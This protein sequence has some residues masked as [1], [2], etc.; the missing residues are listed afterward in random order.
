VYYQLDNITNGNTIYTY[1]HIENSINIIQLNNQT[2]STKCQ[3]NISASTFNPKWSSD[4]LLI[5]ITYTYNKRRIIH[6][7]Q[8]YSL[9]V[10]SPIAIGEFIVSK[11]EVGEWMH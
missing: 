6:S 10:I 3:Y 2:K 7:K 1:V 5:K 9:P 4:N 11:E 8:S